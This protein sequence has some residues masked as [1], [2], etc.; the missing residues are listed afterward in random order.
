MRITLLAVH[1]V[2]MTTAMTTP[3]FVRMR[4][5]PG[6]HPPTTA[7][8]FSPRL[9]Y[10]LFDRIAVRLEGVVHVENMDG[11]KSLARR[12]KAAS[13]GGVF[14]PSGNTPPSTYAQL[15]IRPGWHFEGILKF[16]GPLRMIRTGEFRF[17]CDLRLNFSRFANQAG[18]AEHWGDEANFRRDE[19]LSAATKQKTYNNADN[20]VI[21]AA[22]GRLMRPGE[23]EAALSAYLLG[24]RD[25]VRRD[26]L[27]L[28]GDIPGRDWR[29][30]SEFVQQAEVYWEFMARR[31]K[32][33]AAY[34]GRQI[35]PC[36]ATGTKSDHDLD[37]V[38]YRQVLKKGVALSTYAKTQTR[39]RFEVQYVQPISRTARASGSSIVERLLAARG[40]AHRRLARLVRDLCPD[41]SQHS[42]PRRSLTR[43][44]SNIHASCRGDAVLFQTILDVLLD[45]AALSPTN[46]GIPEE[47]IQALV[48]N[49]VL[50]RPIARQRNL[51][52]ATPEV[53][54][55][56]H[57]L[58]EAFGTE[59]GQRWASE[60][61]VMP[62]D[63][64]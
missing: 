62:S 25:L 16:P 39:V 43:V 19:N 17:V 10:G 34:Y 2:A 15:L 52:A 18:L 1:P 4:E 41:L 6:T 44:L 7:Q 20:V 59:R 56:L 38:S 13:R 8:L 61:L 57:R 46:S 11:L 63:R 36:H 27:F 54:W 28:A 12:R 49:G 58:G 24:A 55:V 29:L 51:R 5:R 40:D 9:E 48:R 35:S 30:D 32:E 22:F 60:P 14:E 33:E 26:L 50:R 3:T 64:A 23:V 21:D 42:S 45:R 31:A 53:E 37:L 47:A